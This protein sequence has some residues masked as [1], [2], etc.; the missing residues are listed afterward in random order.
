MARFSATHI[1]LLALL[2]A[3][4]VAVNEAQLT[5]ICDRTFDPNQTGCN[6]EICEAQCLNKYNS[7]YIYAV[8][9]EKA[10]PLSHQCVC[11]FHC[12]TDAV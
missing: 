6:L 3:A 11:V 7:T 4:M 9:Q 2:L 12:S 5:G 8:C 10:P 1:V